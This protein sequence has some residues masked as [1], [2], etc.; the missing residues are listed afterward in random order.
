ME[1]LIDSC[2]R[3]RPL[4]RCDV[5]HDSERGCHRVQNTGQTCEIKLPP[6]SRQ[7]LA[8]PLGSVTHETGV[9]EAFTSCTAVLL[10]SL[11]S[12]SVDFLNFSL[13]NL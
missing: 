11:R 12:D 8:L 7:S 3:G 13:G 1:F 6:S 10:L 2:S 9:Q 4:V 5:L